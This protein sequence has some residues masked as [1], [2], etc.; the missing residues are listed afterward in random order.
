MSP[1]TV[2]QVTTYEAHTPGNTN[3]VMGQPAAKV[4]EP[5]KRPERSFKQEYRHFRQPILF[6]HIMIPEELIW[7]TKG[8]FIPN[9]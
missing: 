6:K 2:P 8:L 5:K 1:K 4:L 7:N 3:G 9:K